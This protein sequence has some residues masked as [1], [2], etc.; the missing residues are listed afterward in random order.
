M[1]RTCRAVLTPRT[2]AAYVIYT[3]HRPH[4]AERDVRFFEIA[5]RPENNE[6]GEEKGYGFRVEKILERRTGAMFTEDQGDEDVRAT[7][8]GWKLW[9]E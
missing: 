2:G 7:V 9:V 1:L 3:H 5:A 8:H 6:E 4:L